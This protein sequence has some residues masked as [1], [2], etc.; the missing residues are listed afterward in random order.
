M[1]N[2]PQLFCDWLEKNGKAKNF[3]TYPRF[4]TAR[5]DIVVNGRDIPIECVMPRR[6]TYNNGPRKPDSIEYAS[7]EGRMHREEIFVVML[8]IRTWKL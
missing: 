6:E 7:L 3:V 1:E 4:G 5:F 2:G 8:Y